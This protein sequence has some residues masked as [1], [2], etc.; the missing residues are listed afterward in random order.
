MSKYSPI[1]AFY[2]LDDKT[3][4]NQEGRLLGLEFEKFYIITCYVPNAGQNLDRLD[5]RTKEWDIDLR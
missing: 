4:H 5:Y 1:R 2:D 3:Q